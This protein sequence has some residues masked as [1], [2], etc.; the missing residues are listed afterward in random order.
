MKITPTVKITKVACLALM[1][2]GLTI[3]SSQAQFVLGSFQGASDPN[4]AGWTSAGVAIATAPTASFVAAGVTDPNGPLS[5]QLT[6]AGGFGTPSTL[7]LAFSPAQITAF[8]ANQYLQF[9]FSVQPGAATAGFNQIFN[10]AI[11]APG[12][13][14]NN[15]MDGG[16]AAATW[17]THSTS[18]SVAGS[19]NSFNQS[20]E[21]NDFFFT[22]DPSLSSETITVDYS[23]IK[24]A[25]IAGGE[26]FLQITFQGNTGGGS[27][28]SQLFN[29]V[30]LLPAPAPEPATSA[31][32]LVGAVVV[33]FLM[34]RRVKQTA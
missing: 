10:I 17:G 20:G 30:E 12:Y 25:I 1:A 3:G 34:R 5:L 23:S 32:F 8:N 4:N 6:G 18:T 33:F 19:G 24:P 28:A 27:P 11:N 31:L 7:E 13:G 16:N 29:N 21:P 2:V 14:F 26:S 15:Y 9:T 22:G